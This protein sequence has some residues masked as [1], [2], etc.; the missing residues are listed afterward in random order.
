MDDFLHEVLLQ[1]KMLKRA[2]KGEKVLP[3]QVFLIL[4]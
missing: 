2:I 1:D 4:S 3:V